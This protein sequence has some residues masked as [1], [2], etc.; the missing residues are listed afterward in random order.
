M[1]K[2]AAMALGAVLL[3]V[4]ILGFVPPLVTED[5]MG[6]PMLLGIFMVGTIHNIIHIASGVAGLVG[7]RT[8]Q[9]ASLYFKVFGI[10]YALVTVVGFIQKDTVL[11]LID[12]NLAD[13]LL[14]LAIAAVSLYFGFAVKAADTATPTPV[15]K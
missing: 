1:V 12:V 13:N 3:V 10:V 8:S 2:K 6:I 15:T 14:H 4:G 9:Y 11:G 5:S 7:S